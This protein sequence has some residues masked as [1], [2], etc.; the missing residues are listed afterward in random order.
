MRVLLIAVLPL[1]EELAKY[2]GSDENLPVYV[3][4]NGKV[5]DVSSK[6]RIYGKV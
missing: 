3:G 5:Y 2:D 4:F 6:R 1:Q